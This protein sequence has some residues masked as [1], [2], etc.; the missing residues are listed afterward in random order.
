MM[1]PALIKKEFKE[2]VRDPVTLSTAIFLPLV[3]LFLFGYAIS[4][5]VEDIPMAVYDQDRSQESERL[6]EA[7]TSSGYFILKYHL[8]ADKEVDD[9]LDRGKATMALVIPPDFSKDVNN[10]RKTSVQILLDGSFSAT[11]MIVSSYATAIVNSYSM[12]LLDRY[13]DKKGITVEHPVG[14]VPRVWYNPPMKSV[15]YIVPGLFAV[16]LMAFPPMLTAL[17]VVRE[18]ER[19]TIEQV[20][21]S[22]ITPS[23]FI[24]GKIVPYG[25]IAFGEMLLI[26]IT[27]TLWFQIPLK[28]S[29]VLL[30]GTSIIY[31]LI[32]V[33][34]GLF[35]S[36][37]TRT[38]LAAMLLSLILILTLM[39][40]FLFSGFLFPIVTMP[41]MMQ[42]YTYFFPARYF[43]DISRDLFLKGVGLEYLWGN[44]L[45]LVVY[46]SVLFIL[47]SLRFRKKVA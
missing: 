44:I 21:V 47:A 22:P 8:S 36:T 6:I 28:G 1:L 30:M 17:A 19:G 25:M 29:L 46:A 5:D 38:Q 18:K 16:L 41:Y 2:I 15:N 20:Y 31:V 7:F 4:L 14:V 34:I 10:F 11:A 35:V 45:L 32:T 43:N 33:G 42:L 39:P 9:V 23:T 26:L 27:G 3:M 37:I 40:S 13:L 12:E 24:L